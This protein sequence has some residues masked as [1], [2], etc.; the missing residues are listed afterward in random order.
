[1]L[2]QVC[3]LLVGFCRCMTQLRIP[4]EMLHAVRVDE[5]E[6][7]GKLGHADLCSAVLSHAMLCRAAVS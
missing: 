4:P 7:L 1:M 3:T 5:E 6:A 2:Q